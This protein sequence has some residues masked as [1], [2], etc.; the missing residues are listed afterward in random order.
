MA[1]AMQQALDLLPERSV[2]TRLV[3]TWTHTC[4][5]VDIAYVV[6]GVWELRL[7]AAGNV[8]TVEYDT[9]TGRVDVGVDE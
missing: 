1:L 9:W 2:L 3:D 7:E 4:V 6:D 8:Y 5:L